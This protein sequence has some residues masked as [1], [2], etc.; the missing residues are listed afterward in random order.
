VN[1][2]IETC[3]ESH[4]KKTISLNELEKL[5]SGDITYEDFAKEV[6]EFVEMG[7]LSPVKSHGNNNKSTPLHHTYRIKD[8]KLKS[9]IKDEIQAFQLS[10]N[11]NIKVN[12][13]YSLPK[14]TWLKDL[15]SIKRID[16]YLKINGLP[17]KSA[18]APERSYNIIGDEKW[19]DY[20]G[21][22]ALLERIDIWDKLNIDTNSDPLMF[23]INPNQISNKIHKHLIVENKTTFYNLMDSIKYTTFTSLIYGA[24]WRVLANINSLEYQLGLE[25][26]DHHLYYFGDLDKE[27]ISIWN[28][29]N[30]IRPTEL[31]IE[32]YEEFLN[33]DYSRGKIKQR[34]NKEA[35]DSFEGK[36]NTQQ[37]EQIRNLLEK[38]GYYPQEALDKD[39]LKYLWISLDGKIN[40]QHNR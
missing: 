5:F 4:K 14:S 16:K 31:A 37:K 18:T 2:K 22:K 28:G 1:K 38:G 21:G 33:K 35:L 19:I 30:N 23:G 20:L 17:E 7:I 8:Y 25:G 32:F 11:P 24:G 27:G 40:R 3:L 13:Y 34:Q 6:L 10:C 36:F 9:S 39:E 15:K 12:S 26:D 29:L